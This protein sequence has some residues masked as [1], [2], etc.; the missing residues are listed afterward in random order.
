MSAKS[1]INRA[2]RN[3]FG[4]ELHRAPLGL[5]AAGRPT[6][7]MPVSARLVESPIFVYSSIRSGSTLFR[8]ILNSHSQIH[9]PHELHLRHVKVRFSARAAQ[10]AVRELGL[11]SYALEHMLW[12]RMLAGVLAE[13]GKSYI[14]SKTPGDVIAWKRIAR[15][16][17]RA[18]YIFLLR[19]PASIVASWQDAKPTQSL[20]DVIAHTRRYMD[21]VEA[22]RTNLLGH[23]VR[24]EDLL[25]DPVEVLNGVC[26]YLGVPFEPSM[27]EYG[28]KEHGNFTAG[29]GDWRGKIKSGRL[30]EGRPIPPDEEI[31]D[32]IRDLVRAWGYSSRVPTR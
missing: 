4:V 12:D 29:L 11:S 30:Q 2:L 27:L 21:P 18:K 8:V 14:A 28:D 16:W 32:G 19:H 23:T 26:T 1:A 17:P 9:A 6:A 7:G 24:Y 31:P 5:L 22:A 13:S 20:D 10:R 3:S 25:A 15:S